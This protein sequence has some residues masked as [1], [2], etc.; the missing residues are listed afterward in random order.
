M[1]ASPDAFRYCA[2]QPEGIG[3][4]NVGAFFRVGSLRQLA[5]VHVLM[6]CKVWILRCTFGMP[7]A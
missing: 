2:F 6:P 7:W 5:D 1:H 4:D 3:P